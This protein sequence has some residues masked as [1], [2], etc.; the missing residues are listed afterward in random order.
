MTDIE[1]K[2]QNLTEC[3]LAFLIQD[4]NHENNFNRL[5][6]MKLIEEC[7]IRN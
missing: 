5:K 3:D 7:I 4:L 6:L 2:I 1:K